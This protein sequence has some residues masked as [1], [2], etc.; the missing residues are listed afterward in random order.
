MN[1]DACICPVCA[2]PMELLTTIRPAFDDDLR[3]LMASEKW[4]SI[5]WPE[6]A[7]DGTALVEVD[8]ETNKS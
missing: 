5:L 3:V 2:E 4:M 8:V 6:G 7:D 1:E